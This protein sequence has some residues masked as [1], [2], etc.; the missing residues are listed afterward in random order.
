MTRAALDR[1]RR[2]L[3]RANQWTHDAL[4]WRRRRFPRAVIL[5]AGIGLI[6]LLGPVAQWATPVSGLRGKELADAINST[7]QVLLAAA[8]GLVVVVG[9]VFTGRTYYLTRRGQL[10][11]RYATAINQLASDKTTERLGGI[12]ALEHIM[13]ESEDDQEIIVE[14]LTAFIRERVPAADDTKESEIALPATEKSSQRPRWIQRP[15]TD[16]RAALT[17]LNRRPQRVERHVIHLERTD[18]RGAELPKA[19]LPEADM[20]GTVLH[21]AWLA[22]ANMEFANLEGAQLSAYLLDT[23]L[24]SANL[25]DADMREAQLHRADL[26]ETR[27]MRANLRG[28]SL[29]DAQ[30]QGANL[31]NANLQDALLDGA[32]L[33]G[34]N[35]ADVRGLTAAQLAA[36]TFDHTTQ[37]PPDLRGGDTELSAAD[38]TTSDAGTEG[39]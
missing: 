9:L 16:V 3:V 33:H 25:Q 12:Y 4:S 22:G 39:K 30:L 32:Q 18:L 8:G 26:R 17:V 7:R 36:A 31:S 24:H 28:A 20:H 29:I 27:L 35:L 11:D 15:P 1:G 5:L 23:Q 38:P 19:Q 13:S 10:T 14:V 6:I 21:L 2:L 37:L 34:A